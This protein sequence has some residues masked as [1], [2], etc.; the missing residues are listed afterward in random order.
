MV[1]AGSVTEALLLRTL[2][3]HE[4]QDAVREAANEKDARL[5]KIGEWHL[6]QYVKVAC[7]LDILSDKC[8]QQAQIA[9]DYRNLIHP[10]REMREQRK[11]SQGT[12]SCSVAALRLVVEE[13]SAR[14]SKP[15]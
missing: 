3:D 10:G 1:I 11:A 12:A 4:D 2:L 13:L 7:S 15:R 8:A 14:S 6:P 5:E 9:Q